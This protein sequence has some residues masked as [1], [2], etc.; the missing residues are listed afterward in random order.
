MR[1]NLSMPIT[2]KPIHL[3]YEGENDGISVLLLSSVGTQIQEGM[4]RL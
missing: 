2:M 1:E 4:Y 3:Q